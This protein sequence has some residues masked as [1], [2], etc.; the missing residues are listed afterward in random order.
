MFDPREEG[1]I[2]PKELKQ[3]LLDL[4]NCSSSNILFKEILYELEN[5]PKY[6]MSFEE[7]IWMMTESPN[8]YSSREEI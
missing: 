7:F 5:Y 8:E 3:A 2:D 6:C 4:N 1:Q